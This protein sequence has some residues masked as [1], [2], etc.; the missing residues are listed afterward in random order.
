MTHGKVPE[1]HEPAKRV[2]PMK[3]TEWMISARDSSTNGPQGNLH[4]DLYDGSKVIGQVKMAFSRYS[5]ST[6]RTQ[7]IN[8]TGE[9]QK[10]FEV[11]GDFPPGSI[12]CTFTIQKKT[13][14]I[15]VKGGV[16]GG[17]GAANAETKIQ[18]RDGSFLSWLGLG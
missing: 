9:A 5:N 13:R 12:N 4:Y 14:H 3:S 1:G 16:D 15:V 2:G 11:E 6:T 7:S 17:V 10:Q 8:L 18:I